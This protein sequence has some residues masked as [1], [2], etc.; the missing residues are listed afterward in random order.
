MPYTGG[1]PGDVTPCGSVCVTLFCRHRFNTY[2]KLG[3]QISSGKEYFPCNRA[4][5]FL[6]LRSPLGITPAALRADP[7]PPSA[8]AATPDASPLKAP[9]AA[10]PIPGARREALVR[11]GGAAPSL[12]PSSCSQKVSLAVLV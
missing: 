12:S 7:A 5:P 6:D 10:T 8:S 3:H 11:H 1:C 2:V 9:A 4:G